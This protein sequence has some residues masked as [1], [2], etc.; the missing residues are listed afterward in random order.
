MSKPARAAWSGDRHHRPPR[1]LAA[2]LAAVICVAEL[3]AKDAAAA[4]PKSTVEAPL[5]FVPV[6]T[7]EVPPAVD[8]LFGLTPET[9]ETAA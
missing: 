2:G 8:P 6:I 7:T 4:R 5:T 1:Q 9:V 3:T